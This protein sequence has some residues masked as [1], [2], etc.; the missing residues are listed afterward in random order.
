LFVVF[1]AGTATVKGRMVPLEPGTL[2]IVEA[3]E[4]HEIA[5]T[6][7]EPLVTMNVYAPCVY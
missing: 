3:G 1:G 5:N 7:R 6:A 2:L 4:P